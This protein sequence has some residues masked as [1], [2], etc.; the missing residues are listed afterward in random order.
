MDCC[1]SK[2]KKKKFLTINF[3]EENFNKK[4]FKDNCMACFLKKILN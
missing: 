3:K 1:S 2:K 4:N